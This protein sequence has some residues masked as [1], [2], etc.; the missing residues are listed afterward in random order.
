[1]SA[2]FSKARAVEL[3]ADKR[4]RERYGGVSEAIKTE[5]C[6]RLRRVVRIW[7]RPCG[8]ELNRLQ[9]VVI[10]APIKGIGHGCGRFSVTVDG[11][12]YRVVYDRHS[13]RVVTFL[14]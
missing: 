1:M 4:A 13:G 7:T 6:R 5:I 9:V 14:P 10:H 12:T 2:S 11:T 3:H 8:E